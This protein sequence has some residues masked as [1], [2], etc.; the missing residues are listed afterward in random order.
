MTAGP[1]TVRE[2]GRRKDGKMGGRE[3][4]TTRNLGSEIRND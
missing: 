3:E 1:A 4:K 2:K